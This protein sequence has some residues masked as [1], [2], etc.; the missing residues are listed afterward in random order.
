[1][2]IR[3]GAVSRRGAGLAA[4]AIGSAVA[5]LGSPMPS[6]VADPVASLRAAVLQARG[7]S[8]GELR[9]DPLVEQAA[10]NVNRSTDEW[11]SF[12]ARAVPVPDPLPLLHDLGYDGGKATMV[13][14]A[15]NTEADA[16]KGLLLQGFDK[17]PDCA[18]TD[19][20]V[21]VVKNE[22]SGYFLT[23]LVLAGA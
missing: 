14:G 7:Q 18:Y 8:C 3:R 22:T 13:L 21:S 17:I 12:T 20:G 10:Q 6:A 1:M 16:I 4:A 5:V 23:A 15:G 19:Y 9:S 2:G 11:L